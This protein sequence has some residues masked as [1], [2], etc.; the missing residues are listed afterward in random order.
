[1]VRDSWRAGRLL[2]ALRRDVPGVSVLSVDRARCP[3]MIM[4]LVALAVGLVELVLVPFV[5]AG[6]VAAIVI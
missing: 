1:M 2:N 5:V 4:V 3:F 6:A